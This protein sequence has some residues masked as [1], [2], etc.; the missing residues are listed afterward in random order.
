MVSHDSTMGEMQ[1]PYAANQSSFL[2][3][4]MSADVASQQSSGFVQ[5]KP[6]GD[7]SVKRVGGGD[8]QD[9]L[10]R[11]VSE[12]TVGAHQGKQN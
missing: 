11:G 2:G 4:V 12:M 7:S 1:Y 3:P 5:S 9:A 6:V 8:A 10:R